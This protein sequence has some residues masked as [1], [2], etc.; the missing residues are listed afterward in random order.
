[1]KHLHQ[2]DIVKPESNG[3]KGSNASNGS[4]GSNGSN[5]SADTA[6]IGQK[7]GQ[8]G[9]NDEQNQLDDDEE[10]LLA[11]ENN[12]SKKFQIFN[13]LQALYTLNVILVLIISISFYLNY[14]TTLYDP[15]RA[16]YG[17]KSRIWQLALGA[18]LSLNKSYLKQ[19][20]KFIASYIGLLGLIGFI[21][22]VIYLSKE[23]IQYPGSYALISSMSTIF[24]L[25]SSFFYTS[26]KQEYQQIL[27]KNSKKKK[28]KFEKILKIFLIYQKKKKILK[29]FF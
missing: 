3:S 11:A 12:V 29:I 24:I 13:S 21:I 15:I 22:S 16:Y 26:N 27:K 17:L 8:I 20:L 7:I 1:M 23:N 5:K 4:N 6:T 2:I 9:L 18:I 10:L 28:K 19:H 25:S 14:T